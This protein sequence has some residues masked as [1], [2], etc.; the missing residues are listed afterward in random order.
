[1][2]MFKTLFLLVS[3]AGILGLAFIAGCKKDT[4][5]AIQVCD[6]LVCQHGGTCLNN[7]CNCPAG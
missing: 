3:L 5:R 2:K 1:M 7:S 4:T 6:T